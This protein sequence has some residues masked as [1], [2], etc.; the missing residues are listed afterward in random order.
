MSPAVLEF[1][2]RSVC[3]ELV[4]DLVMKLV[5]SRFQPYKCYVIIPAAGHNWFI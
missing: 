3:K 1:L 5:F 2:L 4:V